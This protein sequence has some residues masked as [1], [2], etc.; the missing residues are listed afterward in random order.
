[1]E[2]D[3]RKNKKEKIISKKEKIK[4][5]LKIRKIKNENKLLIIKI[6][7]IKVFNRTK[8]FF[9]CIRQYIKIFYYLTTNY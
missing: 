3:A 7:S 1:M 2:A 9:P 5:I 8:Q 4:K 6:I